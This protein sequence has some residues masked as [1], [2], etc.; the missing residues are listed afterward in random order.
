M[1]V[2]QMYDYEKESTSKHKSHCQISSSPCLRRWDCM[3]QLMVTKDVTCDNRETDVQVS[4]T[5][6]QILDITVG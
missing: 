6:E 2:S 4:A 5:I 1:V 3:I